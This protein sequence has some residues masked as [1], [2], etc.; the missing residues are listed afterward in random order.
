VAKGG[1]SQDTER[2]QLS[3][4]CLLS[5]DGRGRNKLGHRKVTKQHALTFWRWQRGGQ[6]RTQK[7]SDQ[8]VRSTHILEIAEGG[9]SHEMGRSNQV[10]GTHKLKTRDGGQVR[11]QKESNQLRATHSL[12]IVEGG[13]SQ[14]WKESGQAKS[15]HFLE[16]VERGTSQDIE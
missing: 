9:T 11:T 7:E 2:K 3:K 8:E 6:V 13:T 1:T 12:K 10:R 5:G 16:T 14:A 15:T 4:G